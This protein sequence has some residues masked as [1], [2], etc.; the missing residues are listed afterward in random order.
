MVQRAVFIATLASV[1][2]LAAVVWH[3]EQAHN[4]AVRTDAIQADPRAYSDAPGGTPDES[5]ESPFALPAKDAE[6]VRGEDGALK[7]APASLSLTATPD[8]AGAASGQQLGSLAISA[9]GRTAMAD[10][11]FEQWVVQLRNDPD[12][13]QQ[14]IDE[15]RQETD[16][17]R[18]ERLSRLLGDVGGAEVTLAASELIYSGDAVSRRLGLALLQ[19]VQP[20]NEQAREIASGLLASETEP[21]VLVDAL[22]SLAAPG[23]VSD[24]ARQSLASQVAVF[25]QHSDVSVRSISLTVLSKWTTDAT[26]TPILLDGLRDEEAVVRERAVYAL[27]GHE[28]SSPEVIDELLRVASNSSEEERARRGAIMALRGLSISETL[29]ERLA[30]MELA[31][32]TVRR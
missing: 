3:T 7:A 18:R 16:P 15:F 23:S 13:Q 10:E 24:A 19:Q 17:V 2:A 6:T 11:A 9:L 21:D 28:D 30:E 31:L 14:L 20:N 8:R 12:L 32:D 26:F 25:A 27:V 22:T 1:C 29:R 4:T 5:G